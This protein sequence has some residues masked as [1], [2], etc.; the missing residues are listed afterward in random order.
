MARHLQ[1]EH[2]VLFHGQ[3]G[4]QRV[5]LENHATVRTGTMHFLTFEQHLSRT[6][7]FKAGQNTNQR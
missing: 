3:P 7:G 1:A 6:Q 5:A 2:N 4:K